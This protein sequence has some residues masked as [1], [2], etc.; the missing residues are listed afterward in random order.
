MANLNPHQF[1]KF[2]PD[3]K[4][5]GPEDKGGSY[6]MIRMVRTAPRPN[7]AQASDVVKGSQRSEGGETADP[8]KA[9]WFRAPLGP[10]DAT[11]GPEKT[12]AY[13]TW[14]GPVPEGFEADPDQPHPKKPGSPDF[15]YRPSV[16]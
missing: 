15:P 8:K 1:G 12:R 2:V 11:Y 3:P 9:R 10:K 13:Q 4:Y 7:R 16:N 6:P 14:R 5:F